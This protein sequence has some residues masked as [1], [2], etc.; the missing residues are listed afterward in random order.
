M[1]AAKKK[2]ALSVV[3]A[4]SKGKAPAAP[5]PKE[6]DSDDYGAAIDELFDAVQSGDREAFRSAF[7]AAVLSCKG[8]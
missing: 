1:A 6:P 4:M 2:P 7:E 8:M 5:A 3:F